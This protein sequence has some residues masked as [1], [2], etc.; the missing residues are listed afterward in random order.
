MGLFS[1]INSASMLLQL[2]NLNLKYSFR[3]FFVSFII[4]E[5]NI[6]FSHCL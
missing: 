6:P 5:L 4:S 1:I 2:A 3:Y